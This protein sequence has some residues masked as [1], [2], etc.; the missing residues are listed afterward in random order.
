MHAECLN[1]VAE[2]RIV[3]FGR[4]ITI[5]W[6][7]KCLISSPFAAGKHSSPGDQNIFS[8]AWEGNEKQNC[9]FHTFLA[10]ACFCSIPALSSSMLGDVGNVCHVLFVLSSFSQG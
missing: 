9:L 2:D 8:T 7:A 1:A 4:V 10:C 6:P 3:P 5:A